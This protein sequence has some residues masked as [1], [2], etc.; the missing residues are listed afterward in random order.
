[1]SS[2]SGVAGSTFRPTLG[3]CWI[4]ITIGL[5][6][7]TVPDLV[8]RKRKY[9]DDPHVAADGEWI[10]FVVTADHSMISWAGSQQ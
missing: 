4:L 7:I 8:S 2:Q 5:D 9:S 1:M 6:F 3:D 10:L